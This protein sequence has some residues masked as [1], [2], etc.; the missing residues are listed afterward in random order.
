[1]VVIIYTNCLDKD[2][3]LDDFVYIVDECKLKTIV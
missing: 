3:K 1:M 2:L